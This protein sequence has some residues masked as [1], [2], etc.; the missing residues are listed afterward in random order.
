MPSFQALIFLV[1]NHFGL[2]GVVSDPTNPL[3]K[4]P[5]NGLMFLSDAHVDNT[6]FIGTSERLYG[7][8]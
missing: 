2:E 6:G 5:P 3:R 7:A 1:L 8:L 4:D